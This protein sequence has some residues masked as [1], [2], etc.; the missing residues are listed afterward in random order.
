MHQRGYAH[1]DLKPENILLDENFN[2]KIV[3]FGFIHSTTGRDNSGFNWTMKG[4]K[5]YMAPEILA[6]KPYLATVSDLFSLGVILFIMRAGHPCY[7]LAREED[8]YYAKI[9]NHNANNF[10]EA[11]EKNKPAG[12]FSDEFKQIVTS[13][14]SFEPSQRPSILE[15]AGHAW[16]ANG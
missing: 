7:A 4:T 1:R 6:F 14:L 13:L 2:I 16:L 9:V 15:I 5:A 11:H 10:W 3:D 8:R 12:H